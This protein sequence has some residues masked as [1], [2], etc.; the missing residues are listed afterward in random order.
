MKTVNEN[1]G[2]RRPLTNK[3]LIDY[4]SRP[5]R[6]LDHCTT[7]CPF[8]DAECRTF[9]R[10]YGSTPYKENNDKTIYTDEIILGKRP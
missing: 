8:K 6:S 10:K 7:G 5:T 3:Q 2:R 9:M 4:C 1:N